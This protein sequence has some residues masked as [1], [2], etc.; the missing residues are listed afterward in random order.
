MVTHS[1]ADLDALP[2]AEDRAKATGFMER[3]AIKILAGL[4]PRELDRVSEVIKLSGPER[5]LVTSWAKNKGLPF[6][7][8]VRRMKETG[9]RSS[10]TLALCVSAFLRAPVAS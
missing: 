4:P 9:L 3:S 2:T 5:D 7:A 10:F 8:I 1:L 6:Y